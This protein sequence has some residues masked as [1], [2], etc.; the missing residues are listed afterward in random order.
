M[1][2]KICLETDRALF[3][4]SIATHCREHWKERQRAHRA[5]KIDYYRAYDRERAGAP[6]RIVQNAL[7]ARQ[8][9]REYPERWTAQITVNN[10][11]REGRITPLPC[12]LCGA[13]AVA[14]HPDYSRP[15]DVVWLCQAHH[16]QAHALVPKGAF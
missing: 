3:Y 7:I 2:C 13:K 5:E 15:L 10:A 8:W 11:V 12:L 9:R 16:K 14:H 6:H 1:R 4:P